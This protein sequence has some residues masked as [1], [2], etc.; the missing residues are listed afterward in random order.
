MHQLPLNKRNDCLQWLSHFM[1]NKYFLT[2][3]LTNEATSFSFTSNTV[4]IWFSDF[5]SFLQKVAIKT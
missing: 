5:F 1:A 3:T 2:Q 4:L